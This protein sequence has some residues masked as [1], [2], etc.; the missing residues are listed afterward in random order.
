MPLEWTSFGVEE[1]EAVPGPVRA[2]MLLAEI[3]FVNTLLPLVNEALG[4]GRPL[5]AFPVLR[6]RSSLADVGRL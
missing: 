3:D 1:G 2:W 6:L 4:R 5:P